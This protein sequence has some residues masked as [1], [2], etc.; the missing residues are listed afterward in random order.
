[1]AVH[2]Y[3]SFAL[4]EDQ[5]T[6]TQ[7][8]HDFV[9]A[10][11]QSMPRPWT[12]SDSEVFMRRIVIQIVGFRIKIKRIEGKWKLNQNR[13]PERRRRVI[14]A[15]KNRVDDNSRAIAALMEETV[16]PEVIGDP[17]P[18]PEAERSP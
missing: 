2:A 8:L 9:H 6:L 15:L 12:L 16:S 13:P 11:E 4:I 3:G 17:G 5:D 14:R 10:Y 7:V 1:V 18:P